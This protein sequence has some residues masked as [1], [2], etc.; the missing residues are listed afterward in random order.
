MKRVDLG[1]AIYEKMTERGMTKAEFGR[2]IHRARQNLDKTVF[3]KH[4]L[5]TDLLCTISEVL[6]C[7]FFDY[8]QD[9]N[10]KDYKTTELNATLTIEANG[11]KQ[12]KKIKFRI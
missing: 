2:L 9:G 7:N 1:T 12:E 6:D 3:K 8:F 5:D 11:S 4:S 10:I